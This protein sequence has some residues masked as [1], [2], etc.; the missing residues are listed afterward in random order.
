MRTTLT[1]LAAAAIVCFGAAASSSAGTIPAGAAITV[2]TTD[3]ISS[4]AS[5][6]MQFGATLAHGVAGFPA[7]ATFTGKVV[8]SKR[9]QS[10]KER[11]TVDLV[12]V[13]VG[14]Q[15]KHIKTTGPVSLE[16]YTSSRGVSV[17]GDHYQVARGRKLTF[18]LGHPL[19]I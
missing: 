2:K 6:G 9:M 19:T 4:N 10:S 1:I 7:G 16:S 13:T 12:S 17:S 15:T 8:T 18:H 3:T 5:P 11:L 14:G